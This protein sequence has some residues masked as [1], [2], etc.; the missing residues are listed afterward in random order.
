MCAFIYLCKHEISSESK[1]ILKTNVIR[2]IFLTVDITEVGLT[3]QEFQLY[4]LNSLPIEIVVCHH[5]FESF[6]RYL[7]ET[8]NKFKQTI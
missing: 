8:R 7:A 4:Q 5:I 1:S 3:A 6:K 2:T